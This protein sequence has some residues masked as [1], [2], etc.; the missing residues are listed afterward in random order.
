MKE[1]IFGTLRFSRGDVPDSLRN[2]QSWPTVDHMALSEKNRASYKAR[3][4][5]LRLFLDETLV[6]V[7][8]IT[9]AT[10]VQPGVLYR[11]LQRCWTKHPDGKI[12]GFRGA[13]PYARFKTYTRTAPVRASFDGHGGASGAFQQLLTRYPKIRDLLVKRA[14]T[15]NKKI[16]GPTV[17]R[18]SLEETHQMFLKA[19]RDEGIDPIHYPFSESRKAFRSIQR[20]FKETAEKDFKAAVGH[21]GGLKAGAA[22]TDREQAPAATRA[23]E[24]VQFDGHKIDLRLTVRMIDPHGFE[25]LLEINRIWI[26][27]LLDVLTRAVIGYT[28]TLSKEYNKDDVAMAM[29]AAL[30]PF[31]PREYKIPKLAI[32]SGGGFPSSVGLT[33]L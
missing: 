13:I 30:V 31:K 28:L 1:L 4:E 15:R 25:R 26:L 11:L 8:A 6:P 14:R 17:F 22:V 29:Q 12:Y 3:C 2:L 16:M 20:F 10:G 21:A 9:D 24:V 32:R 18:K 23:F 27:V 33:A 5:A 19:C 7:S